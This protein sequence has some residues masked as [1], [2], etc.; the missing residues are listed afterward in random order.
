M[1]VVLK[2][3]FYKDEPIV[4]NEA[5]PG[6]LRTSMNMLVLGEW[7]IKRLAAAQ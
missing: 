3:S 7:F 5:I 1:P 6:F 4:P 2:I